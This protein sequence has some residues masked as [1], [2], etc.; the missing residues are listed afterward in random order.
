MSETWKKIPTLDYEISDHGRI[1]NRDG[2][3]LST[4]NGKS[5]DGKPYR[6]IYLE[7][8]RTVIRDIKGQVVKTKRNRVRLSA[9]CLVV[10]VFVL[11]RLRI[12]K[13]YEVHHID[14]DRQN[15]RL[16]NLELL[17]IE[18]HAK[19]HAKEYAESHLSESY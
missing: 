19:R 10:A 8:E 3:I 18:E 14:G 1:R 13:G 12:P 17:T 11:D 16:D 15:N 2:H 9:H 7:K 6:R 4:W 5:R